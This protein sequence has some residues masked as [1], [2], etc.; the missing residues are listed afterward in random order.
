MLCD[1]AFNSIHLFCSYLLYQW[2]ITM[3]FISSFCICTWLMVCTMALWIRQWIGPVRRVA[4]RSSVRP[5][6][7]L[8]SSPRSVANVPPLRTHRSYSTPPPR[9]Y[10]GQGGPKLVATAG[11]RFAVISEEDGERMVRNLSVEDTR[12]LLLQHGVQPD[13]LPR[14]YSDVFPASGKPLFRSDSPSQEGHSGLTTSTPPP[15]SASPLSETASESTITKH[16]SG[17]SRKVSF[18]ISEDEDTQSDDAYDKDAVV[19]HSDQPGV[20]RFRRT[21]L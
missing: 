16:Q 12:K 1:H 2:P 5:R 10:V 13:M 4:R 20:P 17:S 15:H 6:Q 11:G 8:S 7:V 18:N 3:A 19:Q 9:G 14:S 21:K